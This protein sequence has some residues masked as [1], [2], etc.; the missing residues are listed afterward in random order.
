MAPYS[1]EQ[2]AHMRS[3]NEGSVQPDKRLRRLY[4]QVDAVNAKAADYWEHMTKTA[5]RA[6]GAEM[7]RDAALVQL[8]GCRDWMMNNGASIGDTDILR[9]DALLDP[10]SHAQ[11][12][13]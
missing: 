13:P 8:Q 1:P 5:L 6:E 3:E 12:S 11:P 7:D 9:V 2:I 4:D 10:T